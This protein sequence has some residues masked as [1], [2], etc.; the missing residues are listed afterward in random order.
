[1]S[2][3]DYIT[4][5][6]GVDLHLGDPCPQTYEKDLAVAAEAAVGAVVAA[7][8]EAEVDRAVVVLAQRWA[9]EHLM[10]RSCGMRLD[11]QV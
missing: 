6:V 4:V 1:M 9:V 11:D 10:C 5:I 2:A 7:V 3:Y 8:G